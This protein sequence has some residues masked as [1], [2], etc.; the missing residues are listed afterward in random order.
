M[1]RPYQNTNATTFRIPLNLNQYHDVHEWCEPIPCFWNIPPSWILHRNNIVQHKHTR[2]I[3]TLVPRMP[4]Y[5]Y[6]E[7]K[8]IYVHLMSGYTTPKLHEEELVYERDNKD[9]NN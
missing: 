8:K 4:Y 7:E 1:F 2:R 6:D 5:G 3:L 9:I